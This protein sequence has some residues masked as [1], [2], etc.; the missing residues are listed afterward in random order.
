ME[1]F[2]PLLHSVQ[3]STSGMTLE[4]IDDDTFA[5]AK[6]VWDWVNGADDHEFLIVAGVGDCGDNKHRKPYLIS[7]LDYNE[8]SNTANLKG[9]TGGWK[10][11]IHAYEIDV[12]KAPVNHERRLA[13]RDTTDHKAFN[14]AKVFPFNVEVEVGAAVGRFSCEDCGLGGNLNLDMHIKYGIPDIIDQAIFHL[15]PENVIAQAHPTLELGA[16]KKFDAVEWDQSVLPA[17][18]PLYGITLGGVVDLGLFADYQ[19]GAELSFEGTISVTTGA[20]ATIPNSAYVE[21]DFRNLGDGIKSSPWTPDV[22]VMKPV[23]QGQASG[24][25]EFWGKP[26][27]KL[28]ASVAGMF[29]PWPPQD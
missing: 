27:I 11:L 14:V 16:Q 24:V 29:T 25:L 22:D 10:E 7:S 12:G 23:F 5:Y 21:V 4:F 20:T 6:K 17:P 1:H 3:C 15:N 8:A 19:I 28:E 18:V 9:K 26:Q 13:L 2:E